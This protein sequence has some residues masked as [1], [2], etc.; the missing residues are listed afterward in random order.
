MVR[1]APAAAPRAT[2]AVNV[3]VLVPTVAAAPARVALR[4]GG[5]A[6]AVDRHE[7]ERVQADDSALGQ[8]AIHRAG[9]SRRVGPRRGRVL[10]QWFCLTL[11]TL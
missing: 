6:A 2:A 8:R 7:P 5:A 4:E 1:S 3:T 11:A 9:R 10:T